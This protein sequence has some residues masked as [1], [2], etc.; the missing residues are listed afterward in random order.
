MEHQEIAHAAETHPTGLLPG[1]DWT[2]CSHYRC[3]LGTRAARKVI[4]DAAEPQSMAVWH[5][6]EVI[7][8]G[9]GTV[10]LTVIR[11]DTVE[12]EGLIAH[13]PHNLEFVSEVKEPDGQITLRLTGQML[14]D[15]HGRHRRNAERGLRKLGLGHYPQ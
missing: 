6:A 14:N 8:P 12:K 10:K 3:P 15:S 2:L 9:V 4:S 7:N 13:T 5:E 11:V 1:K